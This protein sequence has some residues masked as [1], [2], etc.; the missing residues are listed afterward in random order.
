[1]TRF[2]LIAMMLIIPPLVSTPSASARVW[3]VATEHPQANDANPGTPSAPLKTIS[4]AA[5]VAQPG[6]TVRVHPGIY[7]ERVAPRLGGTEA[8]PILYEAVEGAPVVI[9]GSDVLDVGWQTVAEYPTLKHAPLDPAMFKVDQRHAEDWPDAD[10]PE[11]YN[12]FA[13]RLTSAMQP[14]GESVDPY[15]NVIAEADTDSAYL[16]VGQVFVDGRPLLQVHHPA[17]A[18][19]IPGSFCVD[20]DGEGLF[21]H[22]PIGHTPFEQ[23][24]VEV[25]TKSRVF[26][27]YRRGLGHLIIRGF[28]M[29]HAASDFQRG[30]YH[31]KG[32]PQA[33]VLSTRSG[34]H[35]TIEHNTIR[36]GTTL[37]LDVGNEGY[38]DADG[39][40]QERRETTT[41]HVIRFNSI[42]DNGAGGIHGLGSYRTVIS[43][44]RLERNNR[45][46][47]AAPEIGAIKLH[48]FVDGVIEHNLIRD[49]DCFGIWLD[50]VFHRAR[51][52]GNVLINNQ[53]AGLFMEMGHGPATIDHN[54]VALTRAGSSTSGMGD[55]LYAHDASNI[56]FA[57]NFIGF[58]AGHG[59]FAHHAT[60]RDPWVFRNGQRTEERRMSE[61]SGWTIQGN[62]FLGNT[63][64]AVALPPSS[65]SS[66]GNVINHNGYAGTLPRQTG[67]TYA[68]AYE[69]PRFSLLTNK[70]RTALT[71]ATA[72]AGLATDNLG[73]DLSFR[74]WQRATGFD[75]NSQIL[76]VLRAVFSTQTPTLRLLVGQSIHEY[77]I[78]DDLDLKHD[79]FGVA[80]D[81]ESPIGPFAR[82]RTDARLVP[83]DQIEPGQFI[84]G[85][86]PFNSVD[87]SQSNVWWLWPKTTTPSVD[88]KKSNT[89]K[90]DAEKSLIVD[91]LTD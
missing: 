49:N 28:V 60:D 90:K 2:V 25:T 75:A 57:Y 18:E 83:E 6:D 1:M 37:G 86:G 3:V 76:T 70:G 31:S 38:N 36:F 88:L 53:G 91:N 24:L 48:F 89:S 52:H 45:L 33:G 16:R 32:S 22:P 87:Q 30:F 19:T 20:G 54:I 67:E 81:A 10:F 34:H 43:H 13:L 58:N 84:P 64:S 55:G 14:A 5:W 12:P 9:R 71:D 40:E 62:L 41:D 46:G 44:N 27:P 79:Y 8:E 56:T 63:L 23:R 50:N 35:W 7:R 42:T 74:Q 78:S 68:A 15:G 4:Q 65:D 39:L 21:V 26:A 29:E 80:R 61:A 72:R 85:R 73:T 77:E 66:N 11:Y 69:A 59:L 82:V 17:V 51:V 47:F